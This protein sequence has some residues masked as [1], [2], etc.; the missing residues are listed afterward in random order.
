MQTV[1][2]DYAKFFDALNPDGSENPVMATY[3]KEGDQV[4]LFW[5]AEMPMD[6]ADPGQDPRGGPEIQ[7]VWI[8]LDQTPA[9]RGEK[10][11]PK[12]GD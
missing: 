7:N 2:D 6:A 8:V 3:V 9:G 5:S 11:Y 4:R 10:W 1:G 12:L